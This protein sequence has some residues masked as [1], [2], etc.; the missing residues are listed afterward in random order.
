MTLQ[1][2]V[3][4]MQRI[5]WHVFGMLPSSYRPF[6][7]I[8]FQYLAGKLIDVILFICKKAPFLISC[9]DFILSKMLLF[10]CIF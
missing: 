9:G 1:V 10:A 2:K 5:G 8:S 3:F 4:I 7:V 6:F